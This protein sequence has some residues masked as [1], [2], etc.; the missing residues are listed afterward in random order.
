MEFSETKTVSAVKKSVSPENIEITYDGER[1]HLSVDWV[2]CS[3]S[4]AIVHSESSAGQ[5]YL[6]RVKIKVGNNP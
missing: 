3:S 1:G 6:Y 4:D 5:K 2:S